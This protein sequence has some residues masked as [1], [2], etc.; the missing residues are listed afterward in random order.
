MT[1]NYTSLQFWDNLFP[2]SH[3]YAFPSE[4]YEQASTREWRKRSS[5]VSIKQRLYSGQCLLL[6][7]YEATPGPCHKCFGRWLQHSG[8]ALN[9]FGYIQQNRS[10][11]KQIDSYRSNLTY[12]CSKH[13][14]GI[15]NSFLFFTDNASIK[16]MI[17][18]K[19]V[20]IS[21]TQERISKW[22]AAAYSCFF[23]WTL[24]QCVVL[25]MKWNVW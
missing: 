1:I 3:S 4:S 24:V 16:K 17:Y 11:T 5:S 7:R 20:W 21:T 2:L 18:G 9:K 13:R 12:L 23:V 15:S 25:N 19:H 8:I 10:S 6:G 14:S 22:M